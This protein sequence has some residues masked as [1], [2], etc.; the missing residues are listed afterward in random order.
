MSLSKKW[1]GV[2]KPEA[3][4]LSVYYIFSREKKAIKSSEDSCQALATTLCDAATRDS[5]TLCRPYLHTLCSALTVFSSLN[6]LTPDSSFLVL[7]GSGY[8]SGGWKSKMRSPAQAG[9]GKGVADGWFLTG[10]LHDER[11]ERSL[12][13]L[14]Y[15]ITNPIQEISASMT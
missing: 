8:S 3:T 13:S 4:C 15:K 11:G 9:C 5:A 7:V 10:S 12:W 6:Y 1:R 14:F 2:T